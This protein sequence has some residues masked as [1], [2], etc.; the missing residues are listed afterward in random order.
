MQGMFSFTSRRGASLVELMIG[1]AIIVIALMICSGGI[2]NGPRSVVSRYEVIGT[3]VGE[4]G[5]KIKIGEGQ[6]AK[7]SVN[8]S[9]E[10]GPKIVNCTSTQCA[11]L[12]EG[13]RVQF[14]CYEE[15]HLT[16]PN[17]EEC[18]FDKLLPA[19]IK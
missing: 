7:F 18:R 12:Q 5:T 11:A 4:T 19:A 13:Q 17:E 10:S 2:I 8:I 14:S 1:V 9:T 16:E 15:F 6:E 3:V